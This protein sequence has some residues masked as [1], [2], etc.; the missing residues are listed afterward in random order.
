[1]KK[2][3]CFVLILTLCLCLPA[4]A[5]ARTTTESG[6]PMVFDKIVINITDDSMS[7]TFSDGDAVICEE[8]DPSTLKEG[9]IIA[10]WRVLDSSRVIEVHRIT[11]IYDGGEALLFS[12]KG[13]HNS[14]AD[15]QVVH[16]SNIVGIYVRKAF[17]GIF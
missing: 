7:P 10:Y 4:C 5:D 13:D 6:V 2:I 12:T 14:Q 9:D 11:A 17:L 8:V 16:S 15:A 3:L 1:M